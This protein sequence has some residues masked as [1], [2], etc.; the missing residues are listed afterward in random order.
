[1]PEFDFGDGD[2]KSGPRCFSSG[3]AHS[4]LD[5]G[6]GDGDMVVVEI[7]LCVRFRRWPLLFSFVE[8]GGA[9]VELLPFPAFVGVD[10][11]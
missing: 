10:S 8:E 3:R 11:A 2:E 9:V 6:G 4:L 7:F 5:G 1:M